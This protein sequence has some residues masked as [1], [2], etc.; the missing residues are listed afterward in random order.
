MGIAT[1]QLDQGLYFSKEFLLRWILPHPDR[2]RGTTLARKY[3]GDGYCQRWNFERLGMDIAEGRYLEP[4]EMGI[5]EGR[6][7]ELLGMGIAVGWFFE[8]PRMSIAA[9]Q[10]DQ[11]H[12]SSM[13]VFWR[14]VLLGGSTLNHLEWILPWVG[15]LRLLGW[16]LPPAKR[17]KCTICLRKLN[18]YGYYLHLSCAITRRQLYIKIQTH[19]LSCLLK[20]ETF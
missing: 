7:L 4:L 14:W 13:E 11:G 9:S 19:L 15:S 8:A 18:G 20:M 3:Y 12:Y 1:P 10:M 16:L 5:A 6:Y 17:A 2:T